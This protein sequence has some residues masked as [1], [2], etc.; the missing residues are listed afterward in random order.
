[1]HTLPEAAKLLG[2]APSTLRHQIKNGRL[3][4][5]KQARDWYLAPEEI[6]RYRAENRR[7]AAL[8]Q[9]DQT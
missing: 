1:M 5:R 7:R 3:A 4:A 9:G 8:S 6:E 2:L